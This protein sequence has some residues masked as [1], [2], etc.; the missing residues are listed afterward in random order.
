MKLRNRMLA[1]TGAALLTLAIAVG[2]IAAGGPAGAVDAQPTPGTGTD[3]AADFIA[4]LA[5]NLGISADRLTAAVKQTNIQQIDEELAAGRL[6]AE[7]AQ[8][9]R[10]RVNSSA[11]GFFGG[12]GGPR[13]GRGVGGGA[14]LDAA[15]SYFGISADQ[16]RQ[17]L[18]TTSTLQ[19]VA[20]KYG[21]D[22]AAGKAGLL[23]AL[24]GAL[25]T[26]LGAKGLDAA[27][28]DQRLAEFRQGFDQFYTQP[29]GARGGPR[30]PV[31]PAPDQRTPGASN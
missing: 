31:T 7:Q 9:A 18:T 11:T 2:A 3:R 19:G 28:I 21:K 29:F 12:K 30:G 16:L 4:K 25:R 20:A 24:E 6:T 23:T 17:D 27:Q 10:D 26:E 8:A 15:A 14:T 22:N 1:L 13:A 5:A